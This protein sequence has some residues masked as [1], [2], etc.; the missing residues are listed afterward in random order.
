MEV[1]RVLEGLALQKLLEWSKFE[2]DRWLMIFGGKLI[3]L[4]SLILCS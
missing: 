3:D 2:Q 1:I 4:F